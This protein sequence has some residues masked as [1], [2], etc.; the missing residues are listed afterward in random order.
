MLR[1]KRFLKHATRLSLLGLVLNLSGCGAGGAI[2]GNSDPVPPQAD[3]FAYRDLLSYCSVPEP[4][5]IDA[6]RDGWMTHMFSLDQYGTVLAEQ[7]VTCVRQ[8]SHTYTPRSLDIPGLPTVAPTP[9]V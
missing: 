9:P 5:G 4:T 7:S 1:T 8:A 3:A 2:S 6:T